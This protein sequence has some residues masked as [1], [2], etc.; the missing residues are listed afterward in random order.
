MRDSAVEAK[1]RD[2]S[3]DAQETCGVDLRQSADDPF[4]IAMHQRRRQQEI[5]RHALRGDISVVTRFIPLDSPSMH[6]IVEKGRP[7]FDG[8][9]ARLR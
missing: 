4:V 8:L 9:I 7:F 3:A 6:I 5:Q 2:I 1:L